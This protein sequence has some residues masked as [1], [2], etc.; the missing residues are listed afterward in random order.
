MRGKLV[1]RLK[2]WWG[3]IPR[4]VKA[5][6]FALAATIGATE[7]MK[8][9]VR[10]AVLATNNLVAVV[11]L[12]LL[13]IWYS[14]RNLKLGRRE[15]VFVVV[16]T[17]ILAGILTIGGQLEYYN[18][19]FWRISTIVKVVLVGFLVYPVVWELIKAVS[20]LKA[21]WMVWEQK[22][23]WIAFAIIA[24][25]T[26]MVWR[27]LWPG[28]Y[29][30]DMAS[31]NEQIS[32]GNI[33]AHWSLLYGY[34]FAGFLD[35]GHLIFHNYETGMAMAMIVQALFIIFVETKIIKFATERS[36]SLVVY[37]GG[38]LLFSLVPF[39][40]VISVSSAQDVLF[41]GLFALVVLEL[42]GV[43]EDKKRIDKKYT[44]IKLLFLSVAMCMVRNNGVYALL[45][46]FVFTAIFYKAPK[47]KLL[48]TIGGA[49]VLSFLYSGPMLSVL[50]VKKTT[51]VQEIAG[52]PSQQIARAYFAGK[53]SD[54]ERE[55]VQKFYDFSATDYDM[56]GDFAQYPKY[57][58]IADYTKSTLRTG[59]VKDDLLQYVGLWMKLGLKNPDDYVEAFLLNSFGYWYPNKNYSDP[60]LSLDFMNYPGFAMT[61]A[62]YD[63]EH[64]PNMK[65]V[66]RA[67]YDPEKATELDDFVFG[68]KWMTIPIVSTICSIGTYMLL[69][70]FVVGVVIVQKR[71]KLLV[72]MSL[73]VGLYLTLLLSPVAIFRYA[74]PIVILGPVFVGLLWR[75][76]ENTNDSLSSAI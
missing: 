39:F 51:A 32:S 66:V 49:I 64:H 11:L 37:L 25:S 59:V 53:I 74:Y 14:K 42:V 31:Q 23:F 45:V 55:E 56:E 22:Y 75:R 7:L 19:I 20:E 70:W 57:P 44:V 43:A 38:I 17:V 41:A 34:L 16:G 58:L 15:G 61:G 76:D 30:Y 29:T 1:D 24:I 10:D 13:Y 9:V 63:S 4:Q 73:V 5:L 68:D 3:K 27:A 12:F 26:F 18:E 35:L 8:F 33:T 67:D 71:Y 36:K 72:A 50:D 54:Q 47:K 65:P 60:R 69:M 40:T 2:Y 46:M 6:C 28:I 21:G 52:V 62:F 48:Y